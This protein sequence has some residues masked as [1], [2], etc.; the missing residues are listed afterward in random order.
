MAFVAV[1]FALYLMWSNPLY[2]RLNAWFV[3]LIALYAIGR[4]Y[5]DI[6]RFWIRPYARGDLI[7][8]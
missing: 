7:G 1:G 2:L 3:I 8:F 6:L 4:I 5:L